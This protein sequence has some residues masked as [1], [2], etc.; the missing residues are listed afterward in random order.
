M[1]NRTTIVN[2]IAALKARAITTLKKA[3]KKA[4]KARLLL[5][6]LFKKA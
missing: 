1:F 6:I 2:K 3:L 5:L 4:L